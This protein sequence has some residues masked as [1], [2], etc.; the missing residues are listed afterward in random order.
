MCYVSGKMV[1]SLEME[2]HIYKLNTMLQIW[3]CILTLA[4]PWPFK[5]KYLIRYISQG[6]M[7]WLLEMKNKYI[8]GKLGSKFNHQCLLWA[9]LWPWIFKV[10][11]SACHISGKKWFDCCKAKKNIDWMLGLKFGHQFWPWLWHW[12]WVGSK[13]YLSG[14]L[15]M[16]AC[17]RLI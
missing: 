4:W 12:P 14:W 10:E 16:L 9:W 6:K 17:H 13:W 2:K 3:P 1:R 7:V 5:V 11:Y 15:Q 8:N